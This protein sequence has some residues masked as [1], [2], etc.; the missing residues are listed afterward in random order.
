MKSKI[1]VAS[2]VAGL[3]GMSAGAF[4]ADVSVSADVNFASAFV[5]GNGITW[6]D[7]PMLMPSASVGINDTSGVHH[8]TF[9][10]WAG[11]NLDDTQGPDNPS[12]AQGQIT[13][14][15]VMADYTYTGIELVTLSAGGMHY[16]FP[17]LAGSYTS[18]IYVKAGVNVLLNPTATVLYDVDGGNSGFHGDI[19][20]SEGYD[21]DFGLSV[22]AWTKLTWADGDY[23]AAYFSADGDDYS[24][25]MSYGAGLT[26]SYGITE[27]VS[28]NAGIAYWKLDNDDG[29]LGMSYDAWDAIDTPSPQDNVVGNISIGYVF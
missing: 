8:T 26:A 3:A 29:V 19:G 17:K 27:A 7:G 6:V 18:D 5:G 28:L 11:I 24:G 22:G 25:L 23:G 4:E 12:D 13:E 14:W 21:F 1:I 10:Y 16:A 15:D 9:T 2:V 20:I